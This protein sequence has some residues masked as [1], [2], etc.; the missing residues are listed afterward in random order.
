[1]PEQFTLPVMYKDKEYDFTVTIIRLLYTFQLQIE[2]N[3]QKLFF[4]LD[5]G[6]D[7]RLVKMPWQNENDIKRLDA[8]LIQAIID[9][10]NALN[11]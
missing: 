6:G 5:E 8:M 9:T 1:M 4:E 10:L 7:Y 11:V 3:N 2:V